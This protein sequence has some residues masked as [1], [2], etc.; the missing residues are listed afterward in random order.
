MINQYCIV[1]TS[2]KIHICMRIPSLIQT[3]Y[4]VMLSMTIFHCQR[5]NY[6]IGKKVISLFWYLTLLG[7]YKNKFYV[8]LFKNYNIN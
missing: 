7:H 5:C 2:I 6:W 8:L 3:E 4:S 1:E